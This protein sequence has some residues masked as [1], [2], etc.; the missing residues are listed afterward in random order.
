MHFLRAS[1]SICIS[2]NISKKTYMKKDTLY[3]SI[4][5]NYSA[6]VRGYQDG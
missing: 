5:H 6:N 2:E 3:L 4:T 1:D